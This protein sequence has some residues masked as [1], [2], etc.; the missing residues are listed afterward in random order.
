MRGA[1]ADFLDEAA[2]LLKRSKLKAAADGFRTS[3]EAWLALAHIAMPDDVLL[4]REARELIV[5]RHHLFVDC[6][7]DALGDMRAIDA[8]LSEIRATVAK[9]FPMSDSQVKTVHEAMSAQVMKIHDIEFDAVKAM[10][11]AMG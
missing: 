1:Y 9:D 4:C 8:R 11:S 2:A 5:K 7:G 10:Q 3:R 6:G